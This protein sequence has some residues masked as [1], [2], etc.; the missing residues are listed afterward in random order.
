MKHVLSTVCI[1]AICYFY[2]VSLSDLWR[3]DLVNNSFPHASLGLIDFCCYEGVIDPSLPVALPSPL[4]T[5]YQT[6][7]SL[8]EFYQKVILDTIFNVHLNGDCSVALEAYI[9]I[10]LDW[11]GSIFI[12]WIWCFYVMCKLPS[13]SP[14]KKCSVE[15]AVWTSRL[16]VSFKDS[17]LRPFF[18]NWSLSLGIDNRWSRTRRW[19]IEW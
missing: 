15:T 12:N 4:T 6:T 5:Y 13:H 18:F 11:A 9:A 3:E 1:R 16:V 8:S 10:T 19:K 14:I 2:L 17:T 7:A